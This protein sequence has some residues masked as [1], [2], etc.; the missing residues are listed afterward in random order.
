VDDFFNGILQDPGLVVGKTVVLSDPQKLGDFEACQQY[1]STLIANMS[2]RAKLSGDCNASSA[3]RG[4]GGDNS[5]LIDLVKGGQY[6]DAQY[7]SFSKEEKD[8][9]ACYREESKKKKKWKRKARNTKRRLAK[10][11]S[12]CNEAQDAADVDGEES[13]SG[14]GAQFGANGNRNKKSTNGNR[15]KKSK[16]S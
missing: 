8:C 10:A 6:T 3:T 1:L 11:Q 7:Q 2:N 15:N 9:V 16:K 4:W 12:E 13:T 5:A 14:N